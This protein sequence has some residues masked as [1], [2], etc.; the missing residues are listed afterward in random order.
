MWLQRDC[1][2][3]NIPVLPRCLRGLSAFVVSLLILIA[4]ATAWSQEKTET[5]PGALEEQ[6]T[7]V[8]LQDM[9]LPEAEDLLRSRPFDWIVLR[10]QQEVLVVDAIPLR[11]D[12][13]GRIANQ[14]DMAMHTYNRIL[15]HRPYKETELT[16]L[17]QYFKNA[18]RTKEFDDREAAVKADLDAS[19][20]RAESLKPA[21]FKF[22][23]SLRDASVDP[24]Y[25]IDLR[26][27]E[28]VVY[29]EDMLLKRA[30][31]LI[32]EGRTPLA[33][34]LLLLVARRYR[35]A[36]VPLKRELEK[37]E[38]DLLARV[39]ALDDERADLRK[40]RD[41]LNAPKNRNLPAAKV[42]LTALEKTIVSIAN[43][44]KDL[45]DDLKSV[46]FKMRFIRP[47]DFPNPEPLR[48]DDLLFPDWPRFDEVYQRL[49][50][51]DSDEQLKRDQPE[52][53]LRLLTELWKPGKDIPELS[54]RLGRATDR[55]VAS[56]VDKNDYRQ[57][58]HFLAGLIMRDPSNPV[59]DKWRKELGNRAAAVI[60][61]ARAAASQGDAALAT[62]TVDDAA[63]IWPEA[64]GL[65]EAHR[66]LTDRYQILRVGVLDASSEKGSARLVTEADE[67]ERWLT[68][69][70]LFEPTGL[71][72]QGVRYRSAYFDS[73][74][75]TDLGRRVQ[76]HLKLR[77][78]DWEARAVVTSADV[79]AEILSRLDP[80][81]PLYDERLAGFVDGI[82]VQGPADFSISFR[83][84]PLRPE[85]LWQLT[86]AAGESTRSLNPDA[87]G[88]ESVRFG[89]LRFEPRAG[90]AGERRYVRVRSQPSTSRQRR[91]D[92]VVEVK[93][94]SWERLLQGMLRG[95][96]SA[97][98]AAEL[99]DLKGLQEDGRFAV[100]QHAIPRSHYLLFNPKTA[101]LRDGQLRRALLHGVPRQKLMKE[102]VLHE[103]PATAARLV[104]C[105]FSS[106]SYAY[107]RLL[108]QPEYD[109]PL[110]A[111]LA[112][113]AKKQLGGELPTLK[114]VCSGDP[115]R[116][117][118]ALAMI[119]E[120][121]RVG[122]EAQ[123]VED[124]AVDWDVC[125]QTS[126]S[127]EPMMDIWPL[128]TLQ[129]SARVDALQPLSEPTRRALLELE[130]SNDWT[131]ATK[132]LHRLAG[133]LL[134]EARYIPLWEV[135]EFLVARKNIG[136][137]PA[138]PIH[139]YD[140]VERWTVQSWYPTETP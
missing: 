44:I 58:R 23:V 79:Y 74:E 105:P 41:D 36:I 62:R 100:M 37:E 49:V 117:A 101:A 34:D 85:A 10:G 126:K 66:E 14:Y 48:K 116:R 122:I 107:N 6:A 138:R 88:A 45:E 104:T 83:Q 128:L 110:A 52:E 129:R 139:A 95:E 9:P 2:D 71:S 127:I 120:W 130:R 22:L 94:D 29:F 31:Q 133:D 59:V 109:P 96:I 99:R 32:E 21:N 40:A 55:L 25:S 67:R 119:E 60:Q 24:D 8:K 4:S 136:G 91:V 56:Y 53:A 15:K 75:P 112:L 35:D 5:K 82:S 92:E 72:D 69:S 73:W 68:E 51:K 81:S 19:R 61:E 103:A 28:T 140:E 114:L 118:V 46:R 111:A 39:K 86:V 3:S 137:I 97:T 54:A 47:K 18:D 17:R 27:V 70:P 43:E 77:R 113:T 57:A 80:D 30:D 108:G 87:L 134:I 13:H 38:L 26:F 16:S 7:L 65:K 121:R 89:R 132:L 64:S 131:G 93:Y 125:Y 84:L 124:G 63:R 78:A 102:I 20:E 1:N 98:P 123:L 106:N 12:V 42:R 11:P 90:Q 33:Y 50:F 115:A 76:F 135:D